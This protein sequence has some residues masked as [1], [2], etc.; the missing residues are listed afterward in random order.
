MF[1][2][3]LHFMLIGLVLL[4]GCGG[5]R[6]GAGD[7]GS[8]WSRGEP[9]A[10]P[11]K[12]WD[13]P[14]GGE[15]DDGEVR[16][17][18]V[19]LPLSGANGAVGT[20]IQHAIEIA[21][22]QKQ[23]KNIMVSFHDVAGKEDD[24][25]RVIE[26]VLAASPSMIIGPLISEDVE[27][28]QRMKPRGLPV[29]TFTSVP[30]NLGNGVFSMA[31]MPN[32]AIEAIVEQMKDEGRATPLI[33]APNNDQG[34]VL[35]NSALES[36]K[37]YG[38]EIAGLYFFDEGYAD[39][40]KELA[41]SVAF[42]GAR[43]SNL[44]AAKEILSDVLINQKMTPLE[45]EAVKLQL[46]EMNKR[47]SLGEPPFDSV[48]FLGN[49][50]DSKTLA[51]YLR[52]YDVPTPV[53][54]YGSARLDADAAYRDSSLAGGEFAG[55]PKISD[56]F[57]K[58]YSDIEGARP[59]RFDTLGYDAAMLAIKSLSGKKHVA[60]Y[61]LD[62]SGYRGL[63]GLVRL[64]PGGGNE[65]ALQIMQLNG[66]KWPDAKKRAAPNFVQPIYKTNG[67]D[68]GK[69]SE[70]K[71]AKPTF[72]P[73][74]HIRLPEHILDKYNSGSRRTASQG[75]AKPASSSTAGPDAEHVY[76][77]DSDAVVDADFLPSKPSSVD[78]KLINEATLRM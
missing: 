8:E 4:G 72:D 61:L 67:Y 2:K 24:K 3:K 48:L 14:E 42:Y 56:S 31:L 77:D 17:V 35:A 66:V 18:A 33:L 37:E 38:I 5:G 53:A 25:R 39:K 49:A 11:D 10:Y 73:M 15:R 22:F 40:M 19:L 65:R 1:I 12:I 59:N 43:A 69:P 68:Y 7:W 52:Y 32:Q 41:E 64:R 28:V 55:L 29:L 47:D 70:R 16:N 26:G 58:L 78:K 27:M 6:Y 23:P 60:A 44:V 36:A 75:V 57:V 20:G 71:L 54:F 74:N 21:F 13:A 30:R 76:S 63:D 9:G 50:A 34:Y 51:A 45:K 46:E 62:P